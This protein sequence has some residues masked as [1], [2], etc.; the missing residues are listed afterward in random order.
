[1][2]CMGGGEGGR[3]GSC[4]LAVG[5]ESEPALLVSRRTQLQPRGP[6]RPLAAAGLGLLE[7]AWARPPFPRQGTVLALGGGREGFPI[8]GEEHALV[9]RVP[10]GVRKDLRAT[11]PGYCCNLSC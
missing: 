3:G 2:G 11:M 1:M 4:I 9:E 6:A 5:E 7:W 10:Q 8:Q